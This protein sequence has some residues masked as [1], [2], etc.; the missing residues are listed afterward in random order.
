MLFRRPPRR[1]RP[2]HQPAAGHRRAAV[3][4][5]LGLV[6][7]AGLLALALGAC[8]PS[9]AAQDPPTPT[10]SNGPTVTIKDLAYAPKALTVPAGT[11]VTWAWHDG[12]IA[13]DVKG[14]GFKSKVVSQGTFA[15]R[16]TQPGTYPYLCSLQPNMTG[17]I[18][19]TP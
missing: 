2:N 18:E 8:G 10:A 5:G 15:H 6:V 19:V 17:T 14:P 9:Q 3:G 7:L 13:H 4:R 12:A 1:D 11:T 16:F